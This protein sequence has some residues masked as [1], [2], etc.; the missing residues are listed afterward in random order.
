MSADYFASQQI[1]PKKSMSW[2]DI[3]VWLNEQKKLL[4]DSYI[5]NV[6]VYSKELMVLRL[7]KRGEDK[8]F[9]LI[10]EPGKRVSIIFSQLSLEPHRNLTELW[11]RHVRDCRVAGVE[12]YDKE[13]LIV[14][15]LKCGAEERKLIIELLPRGTVI[16]TTS[17]LEVLLALEYRKMK[18]RIIAPRH[19][20]QFPPKQWVQDL[21]TIEAQKV[22]GDVI[23][24]KQNIISYFVKSFGI[25]PELV[26]LSY[27]ICIEKVRQDNNIS[28]VVECVIN[29]LRSL[30]KLAIESPK[31]CIVY[32]QDTAVGFYTFEP[33]HIVKIHGARIEFFEKFNDAVN[34]YFERDLEELIQKARLGSLMEDIE[35]LRATIND[36]EKRLE[37]YRKELNTLSNIVQLIE[38]RYPEI[39][40]IHS[41]VRSVIKSEGWDRVTKCSNSIER[42]DK[43]SGKYVLRI[44]STSIELDVRLEFIDVYN[45]YRKKLKDVEKSIERIES[46]ISKL[47]SKMVELEQNVET[48]KRSIR[49]AMKKVREWF[50]RFHWTIT[51]SGFLVIG[52]K[53]AQQNMM[54][55]RKYLDEKDIV[56]HADIHGGSAVIIKT[57]GRTVDEET[58]HEAALLAACYSKAWKMGLHAI[59]VFWVPASQVSLSPPSGEYLPKGGF[60]VY[61]KKNYVRSVSLELAIG[62]EILKLDEGCTI[63]LVVGS[64]NNVSRRCLV[65]FVIRPGDS[66]VDDV[67]KQFLDE[68]NSKE[69]RALVKA[70]DIN[71]L[72]SKIPG[73]SKIVKIVVRED[74]KK[75]LEEC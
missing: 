11:R 4:V 24:K 2:I 73:K 56:L 54:L 23:E 29:E 15:D 63:R 22:V 14:M 20:Y 28:S 62:I 74:V 59:D 9:F 55:I 48:E 32:I 75:V 65:Y 39:E 50:E 58:L 26:E 60:M 46:E 42:Y 21:D 10:I 67:I 38:E 37:M 12:Q 51:S 1:R 70:V 34:K 66:K 40:K 25:P 27:H 57:G 45:N 33:L 13:R 52:G 36:M 17:T 49:L 31:P 7:R 5:D 69:L 44:D 6:F 61:G 71:E 35:K 41:C 72:R 64:E 30:Q 43:S 19:P 68:L 8:Q 3:S 16:L 47:R 18:D 53:D